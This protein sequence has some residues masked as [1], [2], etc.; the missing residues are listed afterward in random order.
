MISLFQ[1][2]SSFQALVNTSQSSFFR[3]QTDFEQAVND[4]SNQLWELWTGMAEKSQEI[5]DHLAPFLKSKNIIIKQKNAS[6]GVLTTPD[7]YGRFS[8]TR[9]IVTGN[10]CVPCKEVDNGDC[11]NGNFKSEEELAEDY[12]DSIIERNVELIDNIKW[13]ACLSH[14]TK[15]P[16]FDKPKITQIDGG[17]KVAPRKISVVVLDYYVR[18]QKG[19]FQYTIA[20]GDT[21]TGAGD[22]LIYDAANS[23]PLEWPETVINEFLW[24]LSER[25]GLFT[26]QQF[27]AAFS[28]QQK[29]TN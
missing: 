5:R 15:C 8:S 14:E 29:N 4:I 20:P 27:V 26:Q 9:V 11:A 3:P 13:A 10:S 24:R 17:W 2:Y 19:T 22:Y 7:N 25:F 1:L 16:T 21:N 6:Y 18:P 12:Y 23:K 28:T